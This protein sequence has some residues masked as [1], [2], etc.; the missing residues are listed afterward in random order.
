MSMNNE[1]FRCRSD[2]A[3]GVASYQRQLRG[4]TLI[5][6]L[7]SSRKNDVRAVHLILEGAMS[8]C[9]ADSV[10]SSYSL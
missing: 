3:K 9:Q 7:G 6:H 4:C 10:I 8:R 5:E 2:I 1:A